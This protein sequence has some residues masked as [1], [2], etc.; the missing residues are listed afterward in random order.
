MR[1][2]AARW[3]LLYI[4]PPAF[5]WR[6][7]LIRKIRPSVPFS[8]A[9]WPAN[10]I[11]QVWNAIEGQQ[12]GTEIIIFDCFIAGGRGA[13]RTFF[14]FKS[15]QNPFGMDRSRDH[16]VQSHGWIILYRVPFPLEVPWATWSMGIRYLNDHL[17][18]LQVGPIV[19]AIC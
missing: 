8:L 16:V 15:E 11:R 10:E 3:G 7:P 17:N 6:F 5:R 12:G 13:Y 19:R 2:L 18:T 14:A 4:G 1:A 9:W